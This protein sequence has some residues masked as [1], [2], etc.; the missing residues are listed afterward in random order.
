[1]PAT[2]PFLRPQ[3]PPLADVQRYYQ[4]A[5]D[6]RFYSNGGP[7]ERL[8][9]ERLTEYLDGATCIPVNNATSGIIVALLAATHRAGTR[10]RPLVITPSYTFVATAGSLVALGFRPLFVD[11]D[12]D[13]WQLDPVA[14]ERV[15]DTHGDDVAAVLATHTFGVPPTA[16][17]QDRWTAACA[18][19]DVPLVL[20]VAAAFGAVDAHG[21]RTGTGDATHVFSFHAT[22][23]FGIG[24]GGMISTRDAE[25]ARHCDGIR[26][27]GFLE[28]RVAA[29]P[30]INAK[31]DELHAAVALTVLD[32]YPEILAAR[33]DLAEYYRLHLEPAGFRF[34]TGSAG[35]TWQAG[36]LQA[37]DP[38]T[39]TALLEAGKAAGVGITAY[40]ERPLHRHPAYAHALL[41]GELPVTEAL[42]AGALALPM[43]ND[44]SAEERSRVVDVVLET[45]KGA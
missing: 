24:E 25:L 15:L 1:M 23:P 17:V 19:R 26:S 41:D 30:G 7:C 39:R 44:L 43:A 16:A 8:L 38:A 13:G 45:A 6:A 4:A 31:L 33:R 20:D 10:D 11:V 2:V 36:Y 14:L 21:A 18:R 3:L 42:A 5:E 32:G 35:G 27:F 37:P 12:P 29:L 34:Q 40:Y 9:R 28:G 22:K